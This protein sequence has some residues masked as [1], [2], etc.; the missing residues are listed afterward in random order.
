MGRDKALLPLGPGGSPLG[1]HLGSM[2]ASVT[3]PCLEVGP[4]SSGLDRVVEPEPRRGPLAAIAAGAAELDRRALQAAE[5]PGGAGLSVLV[6]ATDLPRLSRLLLETLASW[7]AGPGVSVVPVVKGR[8]QPL[9][10]LWSPAALER[11][12]ELS[13]RG[14]RRVHP[15]FAGASPLV[16]LGEEDVPACDLA[17]ELSDVDDEADLRRLGLA[18]ERPG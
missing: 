14:E 1:R 11:A 17:L 16:L 7:P 3:S 10:A 13:R 5:E 15:V 18:G 12:R 6:L 4:G 9:C 2:L 8:L